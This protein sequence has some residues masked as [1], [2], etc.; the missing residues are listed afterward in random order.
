MTPK[1]QL[2]IHATNVT[3]LGA[4]QVVQSLL[5]GL[6]QVADLRQAVAC[7]SGG[8]G[9]DCRAVGGAGARVEQHRRVMPNVVSRAWECLVVHQAYQGFHR[10]LVLGDI[11]LRGANGQVVLVHQAHLVA[12][13]VNGSSSPCSKYSVMR[14]V[15]RRNLPFVQTVVV[16]TGAMRT[17]ILASYPELQ[18][19]LVVIPQ[20]VPN[21][22]QAPLNTRKKLQAGRL[23]LFYPV[24]GYPHKNHAL[25]KLMDGTREMTSGIELIV[26]LSEAEKSV[27]TPAPSWV[28]NIGRLGPRAC[29][30]TYQET[31]ALFFPSLL[32]SYGLPLLEAMTLGLPVLCSDLPYARW[33]CEDEAIYF[34]PLSGE[35]A[36]RAVGELKQRLAGGW[37]PDWRKSLSKLP[38]DWNE[39]ARRFL[40][41][42]GM[43]AGTNGDT[44]DQ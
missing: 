5:A 36:W 18:G 40:E 26:T 21:W 2:L 20:P 33:L 14:W 12:P 24:A 11:P 27:L 22:F 41:V 43:P 29:L 39:V 15:F 17:Q 37:L 19:R 10:T 35:S 1:G 4:R 44:S 7:V 32:E 9:L 31:D 28:R 34:D 6:A 23:R 30:E 38:K 8:G 16:Q 42:L 25:L 13:R 3:G